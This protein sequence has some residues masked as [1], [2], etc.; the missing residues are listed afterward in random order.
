MD[1]CL[2]ER[3]EGTKCAL[4]CVRRSSHETSTGHDVVWLK[5]DRHVYIK[6]Q[7]RH[8]SSQH[9]SHMEWQYCSGEPR[10][11]TNFIILH[12]AI[13]CLLISWKHSVLTQIII[14]VRSEGLSLIRE[15]FNNNNKKTHCGSLDSN[16]YTCFLKYFF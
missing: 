9:F 11:A 2:V 6:C 8:N 5:R 15:V 13:S 7:L 4:S 1:W 14:G 12:R 3:K 16:F 10:K